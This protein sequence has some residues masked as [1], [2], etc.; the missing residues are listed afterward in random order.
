VNVLLDAVTDNGLVADEGKD[1][2]M[3]TIN[4]GFLTERGLVSPF[5]S[6]NLP[7]F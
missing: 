1:C 2:V 6:T 5:S 3:A 7:D 4:Y